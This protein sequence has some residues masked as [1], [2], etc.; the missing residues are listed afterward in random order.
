VCISPDK[1]GTKVEYKVLNPYHFKLAADVFGGVHNIWIAPGQRVLYLGATSGTTVTHVSYIVGLE[2]LIYAV[3]FSHRSG[4]NLVNMANKRTNVITIIEDAR[5]PARY[6]LLVGMVDVIFSDGA[7]PDQARL[8]SQYGFVNRDICWEE[9]EWKGNHGQSPVVDESL[10]SCNKIEF[11]KTG[12]YSLVQ[13]DWYSVSHISYAD[14]EEDGEW[15]V[16]V[17]GAL[18]CFDPNLRE[19]LW[20]FDNQG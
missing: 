5:Y 4:R 18:I 16:K 10:F 9:R 14:D 1:D 12:N 19:A 7:Q 17:S 6:W 2:G 20:V 11:C 3:A 15:I 13:S 8:L